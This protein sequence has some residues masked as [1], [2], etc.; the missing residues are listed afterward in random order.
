MQDETL[1][2]ETMFTENA[3]YTLHN[4]NSQIES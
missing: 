4:Q 3:G 1:K 2:L